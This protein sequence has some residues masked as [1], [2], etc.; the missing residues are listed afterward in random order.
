MSL[1]F[2]GYDQSRSGRL[3]FDEFIQLNCELNMI[4]SLFRRYDTDQDGLVTL[5]YETFL[6]LVLSG[7]M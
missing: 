4:T 1:V 5:N 2:R 6:G 3:E 7:K